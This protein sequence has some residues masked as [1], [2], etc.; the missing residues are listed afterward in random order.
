M[1]CV[2]DI[3]NEN[4]DKLGDAVLIP[5]SGSVKQVAGGSYEITL[6]HPMDPDGKWEHLVPGAI[7]KAPVPAETIENA[8]VGYSADIYKTTTDTGLRETATDPQT[9][10]Y[11]TWVSGTEYNKGDKVTSP[12]TGNNYEAVVDIRNA[13]TTASPEL[14]YYW[15]W[16]PNQTAG[17]NILVTLPAGTELY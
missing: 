7:V 3:G 8:F 1:I 10:T 14:T 15:K 17:P 9:I 11:Q 6:V 16:I 12:Y 5:T 2:Y 4:F 13:A